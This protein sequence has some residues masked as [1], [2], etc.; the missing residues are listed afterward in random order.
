MQA[1][2]LYL[3]SPVQGERKKYVT[4]NKYQWAFEQLNTLIMSMVIWIF[5]MYLGIFYNFPAS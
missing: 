2:V 1:H 4:Y 5:H 3:D